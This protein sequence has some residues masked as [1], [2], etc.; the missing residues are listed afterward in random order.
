MA[1]SVLHQQFAEVTELRVVVARRG[2]GEAR[3]GSLEV[4]I[5]GVVAAAFIQKGLN[6]GFTATATG[7]DFG[8]GSPDDILTPTATPATAAK[9]TT[10]IR[11]GSIFRGIF[12]T[13][14]IPSY[15]HRE[16]CASRLA[17][18]GR[19]YVSLGLSL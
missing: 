3:A 7:L 19:S 9:A 5:R 11:I 15:W 6:F 2:P 10:T 16:A 17:T 1:E 12:L 13:V 4:V 14:N 18:Y 8:G